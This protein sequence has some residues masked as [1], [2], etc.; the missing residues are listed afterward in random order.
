MNET[1]EVRGQFQSRLGFI[2]VSAGCAIGIGNVWKFPYIAGANGG[3]VF[4]LFYLFFLAIMGIPVM[5]MELAIGRASG[6]SLIKAYKKLEKPGHKWHIHGWLS[7]VGSVMLMMYYTTVAGWILSYFWK[8][9]IGAFSGIEG[10]DAVGRVFNRLLASP[11]EMTVF[12]F[13]VIICGFIVLSFGVQKGLERVNKVMMIGLLAL[14]VVL[15]VRSIMLKNAGAGLR[16]YLLPDWSRATEIG[17]GN[18]I[19]AAMNQ[20]FFTLSL[21]IGSIEIF[22]SYMPQGSTLSSEAMRITILDTFVAIISGL[23]IFPACF[24]YDITPDQG[25]SLIF[26]TLPQVFINMPLGRLWGSL[27]FVF[28]TFASFSTV[29]AV[30]ENIIAM[31][32][33]SLGWSRKKSVTFSLIFMLIASMPCVLGFN[34]LSGLSLIKGGGVLDS[35]D[36]IVSN[37]LLPVG[38]MIFVLF[39]SHKFGWGFDNYIEEVN[40]GKGIRMPN[41]IKWY[42]RIVLPILILV[43]FIN[44]LL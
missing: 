19:T 27:F 38:S 9:A 8:F 41:A 25:P 4:V 39:C 16:F 34:V 43:I 29:T 28:M 31:L 22:G 11:V 37:I 14:I 44:G 30:F 1:N 23:I 3:A 13:T 15:A 26:V 20:A 7:L 17:I 6:Q 12:N 5:I 2:L 42:F 10:S 35:E 36:F 21:G 24:S 32:C 33:D 18:V 40:R